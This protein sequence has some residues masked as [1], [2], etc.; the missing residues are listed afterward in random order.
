M[1][2]TIEYIEAPAAIG[3]LLIACQEARVTKVILGKQ[4]DNLVDSLK[5][6]R[7][8]QEVHTYAVTKDTVIRGYLENI[9][10]Y[11]S[12]ELGNTTQ[13]LDAIPIAF[14]PQATEWQINIW[15]KMREIPPGKTVTY[16]EL[17]ENAG[18]E[19][20]AAIAVGGVCA[21]NQLAIL[22][23]CHRVLAANPKD[24]LNY[25]WGAEWKRF[26]LDLESQT[27]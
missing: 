1:N 20:K 26:L 9:I 3:K 14:P 19:K 2:Q 8:N 17:A 16:G 12:G 25:R 11:L 6:S 7:T 27:N 4:E 10:S 15:T 24:G 5:Q 22:V 21:S 23:P 18:G 13:T